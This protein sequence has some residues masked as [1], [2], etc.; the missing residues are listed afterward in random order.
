METEATI[1]SE[2]LTEVKRQLAELF[3]IIALPTVNNEVLIEV[4]KQLT[5]LSKIVGQ[6]EGSP[7]GSSTD[8]KDK[9]NKLYFTVFIKELC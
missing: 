6:L 8:E 4:K 2:I 3:K 7:D 9:V 5:E 1:S